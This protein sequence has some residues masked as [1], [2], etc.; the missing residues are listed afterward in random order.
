[1]GSCWSALIMWEELTKNLFCKFLA[2]VNGVFFQSKTTA[3]FLADTNYPHLS[4]FVP[5]D[6]SL[7]GF[8]VASRSFFVNGIMAIGCLSE[9]VQSI[10][11]SDAVDV[12]NLMCWPSA[13]GD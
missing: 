1:M 6:T 10:I 8:I 4:R 12:I 9:I 3:E 2:M 5:V 13:M 11:C 7:A